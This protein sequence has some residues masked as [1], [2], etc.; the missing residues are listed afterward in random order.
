MGLVRVAG[1]ADVPPGRTV[2]VTVQ[3]TPVLIVNAEG[4]F[5]ALHGIC[6]H[7]NNPLEGATVLGHLVDCPWHHFQYD[8]RTGANHYPRNVYPDD[9][10]QLEAQIRPL[11]TYPLVVRDQHILV[12]LP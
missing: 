10:P 5:F 3:S 12:D 8:V 4:R 6:P 11:R 1:V 9:M 2:F 7:R